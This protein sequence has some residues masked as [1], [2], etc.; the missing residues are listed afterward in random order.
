MTLVK[1]YQPSINVPAKLCT[2]VYRIYVTSYPLVNVFLSLFI[3]IFEFLRKTANKLNW[4]HQI[5]NTKHHQQGINAKAMPML[6][7]K[8][9]WGKGERAPLHQLRNELLQQLLS[10]SNR[11]KQTKQHPT[12]TC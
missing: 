9:M 1:L 5:R 7:F 8:R 2:S 3:L 11:C 12:K 6:F 4:N 10:S